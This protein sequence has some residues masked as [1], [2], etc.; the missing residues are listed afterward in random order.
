MSQ[1]DSQKPGYAP[2]Y[3]ENTDVKTLQKL[4]AKQ[5]KRINTTEQARLD[6]I[7]TLA[8]A[9]KYLP[10]S[11]GNN[12]NP[13]AKV[14]KVMAKSIVANYEEQRNDE[15]K[16]HK[17]TN[18]DILKDDLI[19]KLDINDD[20]DIKD[21]QVNSVDNVARYFDD[22]IKQLK[23]KHKKELKK[24]KKENNT[25]KESKINLIKSMSDEINKMRQIIQDYCQK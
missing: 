10:K 20:D 8:N 5:H 25:L 7:A 4:E 6:A 14:Q 9:H 2:V 12:K 11:F 19:N 22:K 21:H 18:T 3:D 13:I 24:L 15:S 16:G 17:K 1:N 23:I